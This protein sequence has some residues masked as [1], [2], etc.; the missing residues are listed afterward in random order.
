M[1]NPDVRPLAIVLMLEIGLKMGDLIEERMDLFV[2]R[3]GRLYLIR[4]QR[5]TAAGVLPDSCNIG[6]INA[7][8]AAIWEG[9]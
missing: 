9:L 6:H 1:L 8:N 3:V 4:G 2:T 5:A 7:K